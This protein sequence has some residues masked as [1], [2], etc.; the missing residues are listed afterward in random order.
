MKY[1]YFENTY[2]SVDDN[3]NDFITIDGY[4]EDDN[5][6]GTVIAVVF[7]TP[8]KDI[9]VDYHHNEYRGNTIV[10]ELIEQSKQILLKED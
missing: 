9:V 8:H 10:N 6:E 4:P 7:C 2:M 5:A 3:G 1:V